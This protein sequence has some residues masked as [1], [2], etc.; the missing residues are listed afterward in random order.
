MSAVQNDV[1]LVPNSSLQSVEVVACLSQTLHQTS[2][3]TEQAHQFL[4]TVGGLDQQVTQLNLQQFYRFV[5]FRHN[6]LLSCQTV[7][8]VPH[9]SLQFFN[10]NPELNISEFEIFNFIF[11]LLQ[12]QRFIF[13]K[14]FLPA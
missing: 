11:D 1:L 8:Q 14:V 3:L 7:S 9:I 12:V 10:L 13:V 2:P 5:L 4:L 6:L